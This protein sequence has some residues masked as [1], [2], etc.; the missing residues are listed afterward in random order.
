MRAGMSENTAR[1]HRTGPLPR[2]RKIPRQYRTRPDPFAAVWPEIE[3]LF[4]AGARTR[5]H[6]DLR[7]PAGTARG[8]LFRTANSARCNA[9]SGAGGPPQGPEREVHVRAGSPPWGVR[10]ERFHR[11]G[12]LGITLDG[13]PFRSPLLPLRPAVLELGDGRDLLFGEFRGADRGFP[14][15]ASGNW[16]KVPTLHRTDNLS[17]A[18]HDLRDGAG[19]STSGIGRCWSTM[20]CGPTRIRPAA[21]MRMVM[22][23]KPITASSERSSKR[24]CSGEPR[25]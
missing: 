15:S 13:Q 7:D 9:G 11:H 20:G 17:A 12:A 23:S 4:V 5:G 21:A 25:L 10:S 6:H 24:C 1:R 3:A 8:D 16:D 19:P 14:G 18:T 22:W 2:Q